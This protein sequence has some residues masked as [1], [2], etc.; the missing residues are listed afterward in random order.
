MIRLTIRNNTSPITVTVDENT[1]VR[2]A[3]DQNGVDITGAFISMDG[4]A[5]AAGDINK[6]FA[7]FGYDGS[8]NHD[9]C[10]LTCI[11]KTNNAA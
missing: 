1:T 4:C 7:S 8:E 11:A 2:D 3:L 9:K 5:V 6:T 10:Y